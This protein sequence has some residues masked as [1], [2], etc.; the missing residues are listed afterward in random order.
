MHGRRPS[1]SSASSAP[2]TASA[3]PPRPAT[4]RAPHRPATGLTVYDAY[5][6]N[7]AKM[8]DAVPHRPGS[9]RSS[10]TSRTSARASTPTSGPCTRRC[11]RRSRVGARFVVLDRP[12]PIGGNAR[13]AGDDDR[14]TTSGVG[15]KEIV[16]QHGMTVGELA[17]YFNGEFLT[18]E[19]VAGSPS[20]TSSRSAAGAATAVCRDRAAV[21]DAQSQHARL[22][23]P[24]SSTRHGHVRG[25]Q[26]V[27]G[28]RHDPAVRADRRAL[29]RLQV[30]RAL[31]ALE[32]PGVGFR[33]AY[34]TPTFSKHA[35]EVCAGVQV[36]ITDPST[37]D[38]IRDGR[39][40]ARGG[41]A[42]YDDFAWRDD[43]D[44]RPYWID[45]LTGSTSGCVSRSPRGLRRRRRRRLDG[46]ARGVRPASP[47]VPH[48]PR[49]PAA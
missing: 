12:N 2:S 18:A 23:T 46:R 17:R 20:W 1:T 38:P 47:A 25:D 14:R 27:R 44:P 28:P 4:P 45:K 15:A 6:A 21:G 3:A 33:E 49:P 29:G 30:G 24:R 26:P 31:A 16:Q 8:A 48:L 22:P 42:L 35:G 39:R 13:R 19:Q 40:D 10:S 5:G 9:R 37:F 7:A 41:R 32:L 43:N 34:F 11:A 36:H